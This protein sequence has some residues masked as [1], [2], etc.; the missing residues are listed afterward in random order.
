MAAI[1]RGN[2]F[3]RLP[4][5]LAVVGALGFV[6]S[7][8]GQSCT[9]NPTGAAAK[10]CSFGC[11]DHLRTLIEG[12]NQCTPN[13]RGPVV[14]NFDENL[15]GSAACTCENNL[16][17]LPECF[18]DLGT[19]STPFTANCEGSEVGLEVFYCITRDGIT[20]DG[21]GK[22]SFRD[23]GPSALCQSDPPCCV[24]ET[25]GRPECCDEWEEEIETTCPACSEVNRRQPRLFQVFGKDNTV[26]DFW[27]YYI[28]E[29]IHLRGPAPE[30]LSVIGLHSDAICEEAVT[31]NSGTDHA[32][33]SSTLKGYRANPQWSMELNKTCGDNLGMPAPC[34]LDKAI[35]INGGSGEIG[36]GSPAEGNAIDHFRAPVRVHN[37]G[38]DYTGSWKI[39]HNTTNVLLG[40]SVPPPGCAAYP[41]A[42]EAQDGGATAEGDACAQVCQGYE[43]DETKSSSQVFTVEFD[44]ND[45]RYCRYGLRIESGARVRVR[46]NLFEHN[47]VGAIQIRPGGPP[48]TPTDPSTDGVNVRVLGQRNALRQ[49]GYIGLTS[50]ELAGWPIDC[51]RGN[52]V[53]EPGTGANPQYTRLDFGWG[54][55]NMQGVLDGAGGPNCEGTTNGGESCSHGGNFSCQGIGD[56][57]LEEHLGTSRL[58]DIANCGPDQ[59]GAGI[60]FQVN[61]FDAV[62]NSSTPARV[63][64][65]DKDGVNDLAW[66]SACGSASS[67]IIPLPSACEVAIRCGGQAGNPLFHPLSEHEPASGWGQCTSGGV[68][69]P[70]AQGCRGQ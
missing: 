28:Q 63:E 52:I 38:S 54:D 47:Y 10:H 62:P 40:T 43:I 24:D 18:I 68:V 56:A 19:P 22:A 16:C 29:G 30:R 57:G 6:G 44:D 42:G 60:G 51:K 12:L 8:A 53:V 21:K 31:V 69:S 66:L 37:G 50:Q 46:D 17:G 20:I 15:G 33:R 36:G 70:S 59:A 55:H 67:P 39:R 34:G 58:V 9:C 64:D 41:D 65:G 45:V 11:G 49:N 23:V 4:V 61:L 7:A 25:G 3:P 14:L 35:Q 48:P 13:N 32:I 2:V 27:M 5:L 1:A 26:R